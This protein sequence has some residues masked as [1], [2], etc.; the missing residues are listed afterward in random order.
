MGERLAAE[1]LVLREL[2]DVGEVAPGRERPPVAGEDD[3]PGVCVGVDLREQLGQALVELVVRGVQLLR[4]VETDQPDR[5]VG[6]Q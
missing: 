1:V 4:A 2:V 6:L 3:G 5:A